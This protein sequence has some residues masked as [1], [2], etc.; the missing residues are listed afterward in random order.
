MG[1]RRKW[2]WSCV[3]IAGVL[4]L[5]SVADAG[6]FRRYLRLQQDVGELERRNRELTQ[7]NER[8]AREIEAL[9]RDPAVQE[10]AV[11][12]E[13]GFIRPGEIV[14]NVE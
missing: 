11:R 6:G 2:L 5:V 10:R 14:L 7:Q 3:G 8:M 1:S 12:E 13:L 4:T 9:R